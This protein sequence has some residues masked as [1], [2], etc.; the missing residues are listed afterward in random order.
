MNVVIRIVVTLICG[1]ATFYFVFWAG[2]PL[3][4]LSLHLPLWVGGLGSFLV[5]AVVVWYVWTH[6]ASFRTS[7][8]N[9]VLLGA[10]VLGGI[11]F[12]AGCFGPLLL[13]PSGG[14]NVGPAFWG[15]FIMGPLGFILGAVGGAGYWL[16]W[17]RYPAQVKKPR[18]SANWPKIDSR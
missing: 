8:I 11:G 18:V 16:A 4:F 13:M 10:L 2:S 7:F 9:S 6:T 12:S 5:A 14:A 1:V 3:T 15:L 17:G